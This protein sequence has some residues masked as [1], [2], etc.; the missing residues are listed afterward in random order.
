MVT[1][2]TQFFSQAWCTVT[3]LLMGK[4]KNTFRQLRKVEPDIRINISTNYST[5][6]DTASSTNK[7]RGYV[8][9]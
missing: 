6:S 1:L 8:K 5:N 9:A 4:I 3:L 2:S 7:S